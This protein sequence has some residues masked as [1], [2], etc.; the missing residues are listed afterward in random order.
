M[1]AKLQ[2][3]VI[4]IINTLANLDGE[5]NII[6]KAM[7]IHESEDDLGLGGDTG[8][9]ATG[10]A[11]GRA[12]CCLIQAAKVFVCKF[13]GT[14]SGDVSGLI[15][16]SQMSGSSSATFSVNLSGLTTGKHGLHVHQNGDISDNCVGAGG[17][18]NP[19][20]VGL[21]YGIFHKN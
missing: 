2:N 5:E 9:L 17:H 14:G 20:N 13:V 6:G 4:D 12:G 16:I 10:N 19:Y 3:V 11:G 15:S 7:V 1:V 21:K 8:S 18:F